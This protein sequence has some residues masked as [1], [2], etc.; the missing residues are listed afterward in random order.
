MT[1]HTRTT[2]SGTSVAE[3]RKVFRKGFS[4]LLLLLA[5]GALAL[6]G[7]QVKTGQWH[8]TPVLSGSMRPGLQP[9]DVVVTERVPIS[10]LHVR[11]VIV[12]YPPN[13]TARQTVHRIVKLT[14]KGGTTSITTWG[15]AN[16]V[17]D[18]L[19]SSLKGATAYRM[20]RLVPLLGYPAVW[21]QNG[22]RGLLV[23]GLGV[24]LLI[25]AGVTLLRPARPNP[26]W[27]SQDPQRRQWHQLGH[28]NH[29]ALPVGASS[30][31]HTAL[32]HSQAFRWE[33]PLP[34]RERQSRWTTSSSRPE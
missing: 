32:G 1:T 5:F 24:I 33:A 22:E 3:R 34:A 18:P 4:T 31:S 29:G 8:A 23:I 12:F 6:A 2:R 11:D 27:P 30:P 26:G 7:Y 16:A 25:I 20:V 14:V 10:D 17:A 13:Q 9:G 21:L 19:V 28:V 15:D